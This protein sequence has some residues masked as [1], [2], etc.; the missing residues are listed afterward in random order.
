MND[1]VSE[2]GIMYPPPPPLPPAH[3]FSDFHLA[4]VV[5]PSN[6]SRFYQ[7]DE[8]QYLLADAKGCAWPSRER[9]LSTLAD[10]IYP[11]VRD[12]GMFRAGMDPYLF[13]VI[14]LLRLFVSSANLPLMHYC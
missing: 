7:L 8:H 1:R 13:H 6:L 2:L 3:A 12:G 9:V 14:E 4:C 5:P 11:Q 10:T